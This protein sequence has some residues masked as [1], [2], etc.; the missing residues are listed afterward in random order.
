MGA[1]GEARPGSSMCA[2]PEAPRGGAR[3]GRG[4]E[5]VDMSLER[6]GVHFIVVKM[7]A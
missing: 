4:R 5:H 7:K 2:P 6:G 3:R 1:T